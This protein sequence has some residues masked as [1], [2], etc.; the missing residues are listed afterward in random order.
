MCVGYRK[1]VK[2]CYEGRRV[3]SVR[4]WAIGLK[5]ELYNI[6][7]AFVWREQQECNLNNKDCE[8]CM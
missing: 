7:L 5:E 2:Q 6:G 3:R 1:S 4:S 8:S